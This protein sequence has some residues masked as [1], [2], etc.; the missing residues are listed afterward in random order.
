MRTDDR[1]AAFAE[2]PWTEPV[3]GAGLN[4]LLGAPIDA[5][6]QVRLLDAERNRLAGPGLARAI[7]AAARR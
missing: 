4:T 3:A 1:V 6:R 7:A 2:A 5:G